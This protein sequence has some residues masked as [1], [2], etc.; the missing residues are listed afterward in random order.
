MVREI[1][2]A[3]INPI[4]SFKNQGAQNTRGCANYASKYGIS[5][6]RKLRAEEMRDIYAPWDPLSSPTLPKQK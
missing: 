3:K 4:S 6:T 1:R 5:F 2:G